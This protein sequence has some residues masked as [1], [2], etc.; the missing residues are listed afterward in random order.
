M[1]Y[2][3]SWPDRKPLY[4]LYT[5]AVGSFCQVNKNELTVAVRT[6]SCG[7]GGGGGILRKE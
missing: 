6:S 4:T 7:I 1:P 3:A 5:N 2:N